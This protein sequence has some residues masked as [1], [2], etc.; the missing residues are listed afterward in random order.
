MIG[1]R[2]LERTVDDPA[3][4]L[5]LLP[6]F[7]DRPE[8]FLARVDELDPGRRWTVVVVEPRLHREDR[9]GPYWYDVDE[10]GP[11]EDE[12]DAAVAAVRNGIA[13]LVAAGTPTS[14]IVLAG[15]S[16]GGALALATFLDPEGGPAPRAVAVVSGYLAARRDVSIELSRAADRP[17][18]FA[19]GEDDEVV[20]TLRGRA[21]AKAMQRAGALVTWAPTSGGHRFGGEL[22]DPVREWLEA[23]ARGETPQRPL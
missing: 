2:T 14:S 5:V 15:F 16:Q 21:A 8:K 23:L 11:V 18:L 6:G 9:P 13:G 1:L 4:T 22:L 3:G 20:E 17:V 12:L 7:G 19:H 10:G